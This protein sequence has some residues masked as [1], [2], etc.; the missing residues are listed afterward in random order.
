MRCLQ[1]VQ[2]V[3][4]P[5]FCERSPL[6]GW[7]LVMQLSLN[8]FCSVNNFSPISLEVTPVQLMGSVS[9]T[10]VE[11]AWACHG[12]PVG[13]RFLC[14]ISLGNVSSH[15]VGATALGLTI[16]ALFPQVIPKP[17]PKSWRY[18]PIILGIP[19]LGGNWRPA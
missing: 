10:W 17:H 11:S 18:I 7:T 19:A 14:C 1:D 2:W 3:Q 8:P 15:N 13:V 16:F 6:L 5:S 4:V 12:F 9:W